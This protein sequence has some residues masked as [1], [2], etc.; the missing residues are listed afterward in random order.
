MGIAVP[1]AIFLD[2][3]GVLND[4]ER[5]KPEWQR[6]IGEYLSA[7]FGGDPALWGNANQEAFGRW[8]ESYTARVPLVRG[9]ALRT[10]LS[11]LN[12]RWLQDLFRINRRPVPQP[13]TAAQL[14]R[15]VL[16]WGAPRI[17]AAFP[18]AAEA[19]RTLRRAGFR[20][21][22]AS[23][24]DAMTLQGYL[25]GMGISDCIERPYG[26]DLAG[27][28][29]ASPEFFRAVFSDAGIDPAEAVVVDDRSETVVWAEEAGAGIVVLIGRDITAVAELPRHLGV[30]DSLGLAP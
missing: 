28:A 2:H 16:D 6:V 11:E 9:Q 3:G 1:K 21:F 22:L 13:D 26:I 30:S 25:E 27:V 4:H 18:A 10:L 29:K 14:A 20:L 15:E 5:M 8:F 17:D 23:A 7:R 24:G 19:V 12:A